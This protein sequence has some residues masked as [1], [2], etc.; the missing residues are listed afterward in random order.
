MQFDVNLK[1]NQFQCLNS[2]SRGLLHDTKF[3]PVVENLFH[4]YYKI[5]PKVPKGE[6]EKIEIWIF[7]IYYLPL[8]DIKLDLQKRSK[9]KKQLIFLPSP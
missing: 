5:G 9:K 4:F 2:L 3:Y 7:Y 1:E 6:P 8:R